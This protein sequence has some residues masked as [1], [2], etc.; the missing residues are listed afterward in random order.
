MRRG[1][2]SGTSDHHRRAAAGLLVFAWAFSLLHWV[3]AILVGAFVAWAILHRLEG[4]LG[5]GLRRQW[6]RAW[7]P[8][9]LVL[10]ALLVASAL[11]FAL[12]DASTTAKVMPIG[13]DVLALSLLLFG[14]WWRLFARPRWPGGPSPSP[15]WAPAA[16]GMDTPAMTKERP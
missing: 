3:P 1:E 5:K 16:I 7:P 6:R 4:G 14:Q 13:L 15:V 12:R 2:R 11:A 10:I 9:T 8:G